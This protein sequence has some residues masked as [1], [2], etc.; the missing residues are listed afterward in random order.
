MKFTKLLVLSALWLIGSNVNA[1]DL[2]ERV[3][4]TTADIPETPVEFQVGETYIL[5]NVTAEKYFT[6]GNS[7]GTRG[8]VGP[9]ASAVLVKVAQYKVEDV[10]DGKTYEIED[11][12][13]PRTGNYSWYKMSMDDAGAIY[14]D[15]TT[16]GNRFYELQKQETGTNVYRIMPNELNSTQ[17]SDGTQFLG[18]DDAVAQDFSNAYSAFT[19][20]D[21]RFPLS[22]LITAEEGHHVNWQFFSAAIFAV[23][24]KSQ[25]LKAMIEKAEEAGVDVT[26][27]VIVYNNPDA[28]IEQMETVIA[29]LEDAIKNNIAN[30]TGEHP[31]DASAWITNGTFDTVGNFTGW[32]TDNGKFGAGGTTSTN[33]EVYGKNSFNINQDITVKYPGLYLFGVKGFYRAGSSDNSY[34]LWS[35]GSDEAR[36][37]KY[38]VTIDGET[39]ETIIANIFD[40]A[41]TAKPAHGKAMASNGYWIPNTMADANEFFHKDN[42]YGHLVPIEITGTDVTARIG[43]KK[44]TATS[45]DAW[46]IFDDFTLIYCGAGAD[47]YVGYALTLAKS[48]PTYADGSA[49]QSYIDAYNA[50]KNNPA[51]TDKASAEEY[52]AKLKAAKADL[53]K[54][55]SLWKTFED[56]VAY[57]KTF[58]QDF[59]DQGQGSVPAVAQLNTYLVGRGQNATKL[60]EAHA[61]TNEQLRDELDKLHQYI[62]NV[63]E[64]VNPEPG[65]KMTSRLTNPGFDTND[66]TGWTREVRN[67][68]N[69]RVAENCAEA[70]KTEYFDIYQSVT[71]MPV[72]VYE[73]SVQGFYRYGRGQDA[74]NKFNSGEAPKNSPT[75]IYMNANTTSFMNIFAE[76]TQIEDEAFYK[77]PDTDYAG[78]TTTIDGVETKLYFPDGMSSAARAFNNN[79]FV[80]SAYGAQVNSAEPMRFGVKGSSNQLDDSWVI[81]DRFELTFWGKQADKVV[82]ALEGALAEM[83]G[84]KTGRVGSNVTAALDKAIND[85]KAALANS[86]DNGDVL[87]DALIALYD[88]KAMASASAAKMDS[89][90]AHVEDLKLDISAVVNADGYKNLEATLADA[91]ALCDRIELGLSQQSISDDEVAGLMKQIDEQIVNAKKC[92]DLIEAIAALTNAIPTDEDGMTRLAEWIGKASL[93]LEEIQGKID[94]KT[95]QV[96]EIDA[97]L[98]KIQELISTKEM[99]DDLPDA[100]DVVP[101]DATAMI[102]SAA[103]EAQDP[104]DPEN[105]INAIDGWK[106]SDGYNFGNDDHQKSALAVEFY[107][108][109]F[110]MYQDIYGLPA[111]VYEVRANAFARK[112]NAESTPT[113]LYANA[114]LKSDTIA[115]NQ[116]V[117][118]ERAEGV[119]A[120][121]DSLDIFLKEET[122]DGE[123]GEVSEKYVANGAAL[124]VVEGDT[125]GWVPN[126]MVSAG[127]FFK[128]N[129]EKYAN[130][131]TNSVIVRIEAGQFLRLGMATKDANTWVLMDDFQLIGYGAKSTKEATGDQSGIKVVEA[132]A[133][134]DVVRTEYFTLGGVRSTT[135]QKGIN[136]V[137]QTLSN[138]MV[139]VKKVNLK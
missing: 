61:L 28:S 14:T 42:L 76:P 102:Q 12:V 62:K 103:F 101:V 45:Y 116:I 24:D 124:Y 117:V 93:L 65:T 121:A 123:T 18:R 106:G 99:P 98:E 112:D 74:F 59:I 137:R 126:D 10:W 19:D 57:A 87:F 71:S 33:A 72:G 47:R 131:Y 90:A 84:Y 34:K 94:T 127:T 30:A 139:V 97:Y 104:N 39:T 114:M 109:A 20:D 70:W 128:L 83:E 43:V 73:I 48:Y 32:S 110:N 78:Y 81:F 136:I 51:A 113:V 27:A 8:C 63:I 88:I 31:Q 67:A 92:Q 22:A 75:Y 64:G 120:V 130:L 21:Q 53:D 115:V 135:P 50:L 96:V 134:A 95:L 23:Y 2:V 129:N 111:G 79:M 68:G 44:E 89:L 82:P 15:Q 85:A 54:N 125:I 138:G 41:P 26:E 5:Y 40:Y 132:A 3:K 36:L 66:W 86:A 133:A 118:K 9:K 91:Q 6:Q 17:K 29:A 69:C 55:I 105:K 52:I 77:N 108:K 100:T 7:W 80:N 35:E 60:I 56:S 58:V 122:I 13:T 38:Y 107:H 11:Y 16:W 119:V 25:E 1:A 4:P 46:S 37:A 49:T